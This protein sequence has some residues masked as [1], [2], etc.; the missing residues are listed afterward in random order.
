MGIILED[1]Y[2]IFPNICSFYKNELDDNMI[3]DINI[4]N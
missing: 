2:K 1:A 4:K 3:D